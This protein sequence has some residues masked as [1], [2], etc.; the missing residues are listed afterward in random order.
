MISNL[1]HKPTLFGYQQLTTQANTL[2]I[3]NL[4]HKPTLWLSAT[5]QADKKKIHCF[6]ISNLQHKPTQ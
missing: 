6:A 2:F 3:S 5:T 4:Q 1:Q